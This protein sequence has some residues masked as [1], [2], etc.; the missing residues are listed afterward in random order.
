ML[1]IGNTYDV[2]VIDLDYKG[3]GIVKLK[4]NYIYVPG[5]LKDELVTMKL[6]RL[7]K[8]VGFGRLIKVIESSND[9]VS[10]FNELGS[11]NLSHLSFK[12]QLAW[13]TKV[14]NDTFTKVF[15]KDFNVEEIVTD[16]NELN[17]RNKVT[18]HLLSSNTL[19][20]GLYKVNSKDLV[21]VSNFTLAHNNANELLKVLNESKIKVDFRKLRH[22]M[23][24]N[25]SKG[26]LLVTLVGH[27]RSFTGKDELIELISKNKNVVGLTLNIKESE[28]VILGSKSYV[29]YGINELKEGKLLITDQSFIQTNFGVMNLTYNLISQYVKGN[30]VIDAY[31]GIGSIVYSIL[32]NTRRAV[33][34]ES[35]LA[36]IKLAEKIKEVNNINNVEIVHGLAEETIDKFKADTLILDPPRVGLKETFINEVNR[37]KPVRLIYLSCNLQSLVR[38]IRLIEDNYE[39]SV[40]YPVKMF[41][42]TNSFETLVIL[43]KK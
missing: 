43:D 39:V 7:R 30:R 21:E 6:T 17:Y 33:M 8:N 28:E 41:P 37:A 13:Q 36:N 26:E 18:F 38:D 20:L 3:D 5:A 1:K 15:K 40:I 9:R 22:V 2:K 29:L 14:T 12:E 23:I 16:N 10:D 34:I 35:N 25:N 19:K 42:Q 27:N 4:D 32:D 31:S 24:K 11:L